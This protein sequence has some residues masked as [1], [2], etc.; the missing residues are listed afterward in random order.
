[1]NSTAYV[2]PVMPI[3]VSV[4]PTGCIVDIFTQSWRYADPFTWKTL[5]MGKGW[6]TTADMFRPGDQVQLFV[7]TSYNGDPV[8]AQMVA[9]EV[10][11]NHDNPV[12]I[13]QAVTNATGCGELDFRIAWPEPTPTGEFGM[14]HANV[15][16]EIGQEL[17][18][19]YAKTQ[20]DTV[21]WY[22]GWG[23]YSE[24][25][26]VTPGTGVN[27]LPPNNVLTIKYTLVNDY[28]EAVNYLT[29]AVAYDCLDVPVGMAT[30]SGMISP[31]TLAVTLTITIPV[32]TFVGTGTV[33]AD[34]FTTYP[35]LL[36]IVWGPEQPTNFIV[37]HTITPSN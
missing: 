34:E 17:G 35:N 32:W 26:T 28:F 4:R 12:L 5:Y 3:S 7:T 22:V 37:L 16:W 11:D 8:S 30:Q 33:K 18:I 2:N 36:G 6:N 14:W 1:M 10:F 24:G 29:T 15:T 27:T 23:V 13:G 21:W 31:G 20:N 25:L 19:P 9:I